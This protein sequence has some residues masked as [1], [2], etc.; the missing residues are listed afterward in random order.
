MTD[1]QRAESLW[2]GLNACKAI[3]ADLTIQTITHWLEY[4][5]AGNP[6]V[7]LF[8]ELLNADARFWASAATPAEREAYL[9]AILLHGQLSAAS[10]T[11]AKRIVAI[12]WQ[13]MTDESK[14]RFRAWIAEDRVA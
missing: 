2:H 1:D 5:G 9:K 8:I 11:A 13:V 7:K 4:H 14:N 6:I 3:N 12:C 10:E